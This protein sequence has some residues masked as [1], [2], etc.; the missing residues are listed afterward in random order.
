MIIRIM[1]EGQFLVN[2]SLFDTLNALDNRIVE[3]VQKGD[4]PEYRKLLAE[5]IGAIQREGKPVDDTTL[6][7]SDIIVPP[8]NMTLAEARAVFTGTGIF[9]G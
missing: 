1:G 3:H 7:E 4:E 8:A 9:E 5:L 2:S 6:I